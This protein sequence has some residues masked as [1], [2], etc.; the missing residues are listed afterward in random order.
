MNTPKH[1]LVCAA[2]MCCT[3]TFGVYQIV[4]A[5]MNPDGLEFP[6]STLDFREGRATLAIEK[7]LDLKLPA[8]ETLIAFANTLRYQLFSGV[9]DQVRTGKD[10]WLFLTEEIKYS[11]P[12][13]AFTTRMDLIAEVA[14]RL[15][16]QGVKL[17][18]ALVPDKARVYSKELR[19]GVYPTYNA[20]R[21]AQALGALEKSKVAVVDLFT[22]FAKAVATNGEIYYR[23]DT[24]W[25]QAGAKIAASEIAKAV[26]LLKIDI[27]K[28]SFVS[29]SKSGLEERSGD[30]IR[31]MGLAQVPSSLRPVLDR[32][33]PD[34]TIEQS[35]TAGKAPQGL[36]GDSG[37]PIVLTGTSYSLRGNFHGYLQESLAAKVLNTA[38]D[39]GGFLQG[40]SAYLADDAFKTTKPKVLIW[41]VPERMLN[42]PLEAEAGWMK[43]SKSL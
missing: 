28:T 39:G 41:E 26:S 24:H 42:L 38:K 23:T 35:A 36:F 31:L 4:T 5:A 10:G 43:S 19:G 6:R 3:M 29:K 21:Y 25:N 40:L 32:E 13:A 20:A 33:A 11:P 15:D 22:P 17:V 9:A 16:A 14:K 37:V 18:V 12:T 8:R 30:L 1:T 7:Q 34:E 27:E 2:L